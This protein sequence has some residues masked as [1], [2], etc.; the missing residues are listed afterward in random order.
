MD[1]ENLKEGEKN[2]REPRLTKQAFL[3]NVIG[4]VKK[5]YKKVI[6]W[7]AIHLAGLALAWGLLACP[8]LRFLHVCPMR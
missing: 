7:I 1:Q 5:R 8:L 6:L 2:V 4:G 3:K